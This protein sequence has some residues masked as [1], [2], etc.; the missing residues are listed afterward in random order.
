MKKIE[1]VHCKK[2][3]SQ[4]KVVMEELRNKKGLT[5]QPKEKN[6]MKRKGKGS[7]KTFPQG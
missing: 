4:K 1:T 5:Q 3:Q 7:E 2:Y 6:K